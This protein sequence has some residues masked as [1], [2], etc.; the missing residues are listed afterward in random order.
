MFL[1]LGVVLFSLI[2]LTLCEECTEVGFFRSEQDCTAFYRCVDFYNIGKFTKF[3]FVCPEGLVFDETLSV[4]NWPEQSAPCEEVTTVGEVESSGDGEATTEG[5]DSVEVED[6]GDADEDAG[7][8]EESSNVIITPSFDY[9]C[10]EEGLFGHDSNCAK[11]WLCKESNGSLDDAELYRCP[12]GYL[13]DENVLRCQKE[14]DVECEKAP[15]SV[16]ERLETPAI[17]LQ[18]SELDSFFRKWSF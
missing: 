14:E 4:C 6:G 3:D 8:E 16:Q 1:K 10:T 5:S 7:G 15:D 11:F 2:S 13:F 12:D 17:T 9:V 18:V